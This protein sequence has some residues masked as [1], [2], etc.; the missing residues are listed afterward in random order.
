MRISKPPLFVAAAALAAAALLAHATVPQAFQRTAAPLLAQAPPGG[1]APPAQ[2]RPAT[3]IAVCD[4]A[5]VFENCR[6]A[7]ELKDELKQRR[8]ALKAESDRQLKA[9]S[10]LSAELKELKVGSKAHEEAL[11]KL[12]KMQLDR[13]VWGKLEDAKLRRWHLNHTKALYAEIVR[14]IARVAKE[15]GIQV[16]LYQDH[17]EE[18]GAEYAQ[19]LDSIS[20]RKVL[21]SDP[22]ADLTAIVL[23]HVNEAHRTQ[24]P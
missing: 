3:R 19:V 14:M 9:I 23:R 18:L 20:R 10:D 11:G 4:V 5:E 12:E 17:R 21:Y 6:R 15:Q 8:L 1:P 7:T 13:E 24:R 16:V 22:A 2:L